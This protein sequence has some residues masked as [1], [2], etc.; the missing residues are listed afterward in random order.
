MTNK[1]RFLSICEQQIHREG[2]PALM[3][4]LEKSDFYEAPASTRYHGNHPGGLLEHSLNV[5]D[6]LNRLRSAFPEVPMSDE[7]AAIISLFHDL[8]K[9][10]MYQPEKRN[11]KTPDGRW[12]QYDAYSIQEKFCFGGHGSKSVF[13]VQ[14]FLKLTPEEAVAINCHMG[15][16]GG[17]QYVGK[18]FEQYP[19]AWFLHVA[20]G[21]ATYIKEGKKGE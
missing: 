2:L 17:D 15:A 9:V 1:E 6:E 8:C 11:R 5:F 12:E 7:T 20:D 3:A 14:T 4:W 13:L 21:A 10:N 18:S 16:F 19:M